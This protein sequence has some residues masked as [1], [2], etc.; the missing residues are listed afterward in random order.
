MPKLVSKS[1]RELSATVVLIIAV[2]VSLALLTMWGR[3]GDSGV[4]HSVRTAVATISSP[5]QK[6]G[7]VVSTPF[8]AIGNGVTN[9]AAPTED[10]LALQQENAQLKS[11]LIQYEEYKVENER[12]TALLE[13]S[14]QYD[15][16]SVVAN[17][18]SHSTD[19]WNR[20]ITIDKGSAAGM[21]VGM[22]VMTGSGLVGQI[23]S[24]SPGTSVVRL[25]TDERSG[26]S[27]TLQKSRAEGILSGSVD[28][29]LYME[30][31][32]I[33]TEVE[34]GEGV[35]TSGNGGVY[36]KG[37]TVGVV[38]R[39]EG[40]PT[41]TYHT[42]VIQP[43]ASENI[44]G[45]VIVL[46]GVTLEGSSSSDDEGDD[47]GASQDVSAPL[48]EKTTEADDSDDE[49]SG[50]GDAAGDGENQGDGGGE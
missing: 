26:V 10:L 22:P 46:T 42:L 19:S 39:I 48:D 1:R 33:A 40:S 15:D 5:F 50:E 32:P 6:A 16:E 34:L 8:H 43:L 38:S 20:T 24:V 30:F 4:L 11:E 12:L 35:I 45:E 37:I 29:L 36:P 18:V 44:T 25:I 3:E 21:A 41:D 31:V 27:V 17:V 7:S 47:T 2:V 13:I 28:G 23:E 9:A 14:T 49:E